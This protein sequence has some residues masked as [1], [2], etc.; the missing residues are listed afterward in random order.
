MPIMHISAISFP[1]IY[2]CR[3]QENGFFLRA[4]HFKE[5]RRGSLMA[6]MM[7]LNNVYNHYLV[8]YSRGTMSK[9]D[10]HKKSEL[11][12][13]YNSIVKMNKEAPLYLL[14]IDRPSQAFA[15]DI[16]EGARELHHTIASLGDWKTTNSSTRKWHHQV[17]RTSSAPNISVPP[18][19]PAPFPPMTLR[20]KH[21][22]HRRL[23]MV[24]F[25]RQT[26]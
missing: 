9:Y 10:T 20:L 7:A 13:I 1:Y 2:Y 23:T 25:C 24:F 16:K 18:R 11:R 21:S 17:T 4:Y 14:N 8:T 3:T 15:V 6:N 19:I 26:R 12:G 5:E 22:P